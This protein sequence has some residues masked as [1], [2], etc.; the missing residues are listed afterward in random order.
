MW[1]K[2]V[3]KANLSCGKGLRES[4]NENC[5]STSSNDYVQA[6]YSS[7]YVY[8]HTGLLP[9]YSSIA[10]YH[11]DIDTV[12]VQFANTSGESSWTVSEIVYNRIIR[13]LTK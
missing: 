4:K 10:R 9:G 11:K 8:E 6:I 2:P 1:S 5:S 12:V 7:I 13:I 3:N